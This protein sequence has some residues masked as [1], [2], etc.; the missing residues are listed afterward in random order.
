[1][2]RDADIPKATFRTG[3]AL[4][5]G[6]GLSKNVQ[7]VRNEDVSEA[8]ARTPKPWPWEYAGCRNCQ[9]LRI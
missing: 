6:N 4:K 7:I 1:M 3:A 2:Q 5:P 8:K 9:P